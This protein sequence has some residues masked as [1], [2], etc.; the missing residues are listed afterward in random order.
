MANKEQQQIADF[1]ETFGT[2]SGSRIVIRRISNIKDK[3]KK[4]KLIPIQ[5]SAY[6]YF[7]MNI[8][9]DPLILPKLYAAFVAITGPSD[10]RYDNYKG[11]Y[12]FTFELTVN[13]NHNTSQYL[14]HIYHYR[15]YIMFSVDQIVAK[16]DPRDQNRYYQPDDMLFSDKEICSFSYYFCHCL[17]ERT[18]DYKPEPFVKYSNSNLLIFG[19]LKDE[20]FYK[21]YDN[22]EEY[23]H[24]RER[25][26]AELDRV[27]N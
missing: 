19:Y 13:K 7:S 20:F 17:L 14:Y 16:S 25:L 18:K 3:F 2:D 26:E 12:S 23:I 1:I 22:Q 5:N 10:S 11:S 15:S 9:K 21:S 6:F 27:L 24:Q 4:L 8:I